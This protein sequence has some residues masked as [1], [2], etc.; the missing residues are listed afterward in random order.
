MRVRTSTALPEAGA[1]S[2]VRVVPVNVYAS[3]CWATPL[4]VTNIC[5][6]DVGVVLRVNATAESF[7]VNEFLITCSVAPTVS[8]LVILIA[9]SYTHLRAHET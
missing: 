6:S 7:P 9:V 8:I 5:S 2:R 3:T 4:M 1:E